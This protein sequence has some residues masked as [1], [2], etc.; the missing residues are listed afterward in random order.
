MDTESTTLPQ[1]TAFDLLS[2]GR[3]RL[4]LRRLQGTDGIE[5]GELATE[6]A[7]IENDRAPEELSAQ[8]RK[9]TYVSLYQTHV[10]KLEDSG[11]VT[12]DPESGLVSP[13]DRVDE[14]VAYFDTETND[15]AWDRVYLVVAVVGLFVYALVS[16]LGTQLVR[17]IYVG[18]VVLIGIVVVSLV[19]R[20]YAAH[21]DT[22]TPSIPE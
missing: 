18:T 22:P 10:P 5:L 1:D 16:L 7:A 3:R 13:T 14:L 4:L 8:Q 17:P 20:R 11:V 12:F 15:I 6:L 2:N 21:S 19:H 9:R